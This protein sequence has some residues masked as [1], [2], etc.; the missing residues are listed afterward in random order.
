MYAVAFQRTFWWRL[1]EDQPPRGGVGDRAW[2]GWGP[3]GIRRVLGPH[4]P[5]VLGR[6]ARLADSPSSPEPLTLRGGCLSPAVLRG[7]V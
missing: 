6:S 7:T 4:E 5:A 3:S 1:R 2:P